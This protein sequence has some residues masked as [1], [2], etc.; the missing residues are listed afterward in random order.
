ML[1]PSP[2]HLISF[3]P[4]GANRDREP[5]R[6]EEVQQANKVRE[7][8]QMHSEHPQD[9]QARLAKS[10]QA[11][12]PAN[13]FNKNRACHSKREWAGHRFLRKRNWVCLRRKRAE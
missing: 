12:G 6:I 10:P 8:N 11:P 5:K 4:T 13:G 7:R 2:T 1:C 3:A 9:E